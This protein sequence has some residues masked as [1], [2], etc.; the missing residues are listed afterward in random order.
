MR[1]T[2][3]ASDLGGLLDTLFEPI[4]SMINVEKYLRY[5]LQ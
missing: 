3:V 5:N 2:K 4:T 1:L